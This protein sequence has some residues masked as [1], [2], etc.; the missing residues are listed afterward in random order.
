MNRSSVVY[1]LKILKINSNDNF[2]N[3]K[4]SKI[5]VRNLIIIKLAFLA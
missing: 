4:N 5:Y 1:P 2:L 3:L